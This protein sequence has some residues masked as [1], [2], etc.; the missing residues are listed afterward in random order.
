[1]IDPYWHC[2][3]VGHHHTVAM[4][5][6]PQHASVSCHSRFG[7][8]LCDSPYLDSFH[9]GPG[10]DTCRDCL[11]GSCK[12]QSGWREQEFLYVA[13]SSLLTIPPK[14]KTTL[15]PVNVLDRRSSDRRRRKKM[16]KHWR[17]RR[18]RG[19]EDRKVG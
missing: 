10:I 2:L 19:C 12:H 11:Y 3:I 9:M 18:M 1:M 7:Y 14:F 17:K 4:K 6:F 5:Q 15:Q 8:D 13:C 16:E